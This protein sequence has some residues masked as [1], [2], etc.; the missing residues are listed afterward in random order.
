MDH[1]AHIPNS[2]QPSPTPSPRSD[3]AWVLK[4]VE[5]LMSA[6][7]KADYHDPEGFIAT[8]GAIL[9]GYDPEIVEYVTDPKTG[10]QRRSKWPPSPAEVIEA[11]TAEVNWRNRVTVNLGLQPLAKLPAPERTDDQNYTAMVKK[12]G[13]PF[14][15]FESGRK[16]DYRG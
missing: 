9:E 1:F 2:N 7:R 16:L 15:V 14:G 6:Y 5:L 12:H 4:R 11:C 13:R 10:I 8:L 3:S